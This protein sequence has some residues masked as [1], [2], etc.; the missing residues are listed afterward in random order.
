MKHQ[1][2]Q[3]TEIKYIKDNNLYQNLGIIRCKLI[4]HHESLKYDYFDNL[5]KQY[6]ILIIVE[7]YQYNNISLLNLT[8]L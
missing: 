7:L 6:F 2:L 1:G 3:H 8:C 4:E 5:I